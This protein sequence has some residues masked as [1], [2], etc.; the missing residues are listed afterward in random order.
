LLAK[1]TGEAK[2]VVP[3][4]NTGSNIEVD[5]PQMFNGETS[6]VLGFLTTCRLYIR[7]RIRD[8]AVKE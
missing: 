6:K 5:K 4:S 7:V 2:A 8:A 1:L 3:Q